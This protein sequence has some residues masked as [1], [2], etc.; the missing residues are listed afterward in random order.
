[1]T[2][3]SESFTLYGERAERFR[4]VRK[5]IE[6]RLGYEPSNAE[7]IG[8]VMSEWNEGETFGLLQR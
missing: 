3:P 6:E 2:K 1:M 5:D 8:L 7:A 4:E